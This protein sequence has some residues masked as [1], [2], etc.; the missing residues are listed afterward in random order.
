MRDKEPAVPIS[1]K[2]VE[3]QNRKKELH[4]TPQGRQIL[5]GLLSMFGVDIHGRLERF[6]IGVSRSNHAQPQNVQDF[7]IARAAAK[8]ERR[9]ASRNSVYAISNFIKRS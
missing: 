5:F 1:E 8:R 3:E 2:E 7:L 6:R 9:A 4:S